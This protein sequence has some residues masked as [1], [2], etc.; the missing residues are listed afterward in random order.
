MRTNTVDILNDEFRTRKR[1][2]WE[3]YKEGHP[4]QAYRVGPP[5]WMVLEEWKG[6]KVESFLAAAQRLR[7]REFPGGYEEAR[8]IEY[9]R[10]DDYGKK[11]WEIVAGRAPQNGA[12]T[13][14][15][16]EADVE[17]VTEAA[18]CEKCGLRTRARGRAKCWGCIK[19]GQR[20]HDDT[21]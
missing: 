14:I 16:V 17:I 8:R 11:V 6:E 3:E 7:E 1:G 15:M 19:E 2:E 12:R 18:M 13:T 21:A 20:R 5:S 4:C 9:G 10:L